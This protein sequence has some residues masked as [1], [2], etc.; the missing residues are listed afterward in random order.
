ML[1]TSPLGGKKVLF[2][3]HKAAD[4]VFGQ[5]EFQRS[6]EIAPSDWDIT[7]RYQNFTVVEEAGT[8]WTRKHRLVFPL[9]VLL[10]TYDEAISSFERRCFA[11]SRDPVP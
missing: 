5:D 6:D 10:D 4:R 2:R 11:E 9:R 1:A 3:P 8:T 7:V